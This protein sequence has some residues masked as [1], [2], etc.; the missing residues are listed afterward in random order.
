MATTDSISIEA[1]DDRVHIQELTVY[2][3]E[4]VDYL[5]EFE[6]DQQENALQRAIRV[7]ASALQL[8]ETSHEAELVER[9]FGQLESEFQEQLDDL[10]DELDDRFDEDGGQVPRILEKHLGEDGN[11]E[12]HFEDVFGEDGKLV[13]Q[14]DDH[15]GE[16]GEKFQKALDPDVEGTPTYRLKQNIVAEIEKI[17]EQMI[18]DEAREE[19]RE[20]TRFRGFDFEEQLETILEDLVGQT[21]NQFEDTSQ[22]VGSKGNSRKG[23]FVITLGETGQRIVAEAKNGAFDGTVESEMEEAI[24]NRE[25]DYGIFVASSTEYLPTTKLGWFSEVDQDY[26][27][28]ALSEDGED[29][30]DPRFFKFA[31]HWARTR[32]LLSSVEV[33]SDLDPEAIKSE[34]DGIEEAIKQFKQVRTKCSDLENSVDEIRSILNSIEDEVTS[35]MTRLEGELGVGAD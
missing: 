9:R 21:S 28:V 15:I 11:L 33:S 14:L 32:T 7:G 34:L 17:K 4:V 35:R 18:G 6:E 10:E 31:Y 30:I 27:V 1:D 20:E 25:A 8:V 22:E 24:E 26:V 12:E 19:V 2:D 3:R 23:D 29:E 16:D 5:A 13:E